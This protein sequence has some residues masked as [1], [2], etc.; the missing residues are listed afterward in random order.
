MDVLTTGKTRRLQ[1]CATP[2]GVFSVLAIDHRNNLRRS[3]NPQAPSTV[4]D[5][6]LVEFKLAVVE[7]LAPASSSVLIDPMYGAGPAIASG[8]LPGTRGLIVSLERSGYTGD[9]SAR[10]SELLPEIGRAH[11]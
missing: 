9:P 10:V 4:P 2:E 11:V 5:E 6:V 8:A 1:Q 3:L 7:A